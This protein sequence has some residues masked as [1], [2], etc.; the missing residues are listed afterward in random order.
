M[1]SQTLQV[2]TE[3]SRGVGGGPSKPE[4]KE[5]AACGRRAASGRAVARWRDGPHDGA[6]TPPSR[7]QGKTH[8]VGPTFASCPRILTENP[9][10]SLRVDP[11][12][13]STLCELQVP[14]Q[15]AR[16][17]PGRAEGGSGAAPKSV[18][19]VVVRRTR[20]RATAAGAAGATRPLAAAK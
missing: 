4:A 11:D 3:L 18:V 17:T 15:A 16:A 13:G 1:P 5:E 19:S 6:I 14:G 8:R 12:A 9:Y 2:S 10:T 7:S 20:G